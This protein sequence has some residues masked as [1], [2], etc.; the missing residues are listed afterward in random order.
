[1]FEGRYGKALTIGLIVLILIVIGV[2]IFF[3]IDYVN[4]MK[5]NQDLQNAVDRFEG[6]VNKQED[7]ENKDKNNNEQSTGEDIQLNIQIENIEV[8]YPTDSDQINT[9][10]G[11]PVVGIIEVPKLDLKY[12]VLEDGSKDAIEVSVAINVGPGLNR[13]GNTVIIGHNYRNGTFF[14]N[15]KKLN[16]E[17]KIYITDKTGTKLEYTIFSIYTTTPEDSDYMDRDTGGKKEITLVTCTDDTKSRI[18]IC[19]RAEG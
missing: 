17:E 1:M 11:F 3:T 10:K 15:N 4:S 12:P 6:A 18:I 2:L 7:E 8:S 13:E 5:T 9:Y 16:K 19:A 14:S